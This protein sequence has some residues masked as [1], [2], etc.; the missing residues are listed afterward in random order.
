MWLCCSCGWHVVWHGA[1]NFGGASDSTT[2][3]VILPSQAAHGMTVQV[4]LE[5]A[6]SAACVQVLS[7]CIVRPDTK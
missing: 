6:G 5:C 3:L 4:I 2:L 7:P 1:L